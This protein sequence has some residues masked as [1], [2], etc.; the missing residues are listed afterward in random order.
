MKSVEFYKVV[1]YI[2]G[3]LS[4]FDTEDDRKVESNYWSL[5]NKS[6]NEKYLDKDYFIIKDSK[7]FIEFIEAND[8]YIFG[9]LG[10]SDQIKEDI[11][12]RV[13]NENDVDITGLYLE[14]YCYFYFRRSDKFISVLKNYQI[15]SFR[16]YFSSFLNKFLSDRI[17]SM[18]VV[19]VQD[20][21]IK[22]KII[23]MTKLANINLVFDQDSIVGDELLSLKDSL[24]L[25]NTNL[26]KVTLDIKFKNK[27]ISPDFQSLLQND[28]K[29]KSD[30]KKFKVTGQG[31]NGE[32]E[33]F[34]LVEQWLT[35]SV[36]INIDD[37]DLIQDNLSIIK[38]A[39]EISL[40][41]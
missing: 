31:P 19:R 32:D 23:G 28:E 15:P 9:I 10:K 24:Y 17:T 16:K 25:S 3:Q 22:N 34:E 21:D 12:Q 40:P 26:S 11:L 38:E 27:P 30:F 1:T 36:D 20:K 4:L 33:T 39:L 7:F 8:E 18:E 37:D 13:Y 5:V 2:D 14:T 35:K 6:I 29:I 41:N